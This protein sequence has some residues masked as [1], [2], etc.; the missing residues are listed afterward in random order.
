MVDDVSPP[1]APD[2]FFRADIRVGRVS[3]A[4][5]FPEARKPAFKL[6][7]DFGPLGYR[8]SSAQ[9]TK[10]YTPEQLVGRLV[11]AVVN[12]PAR[13]IAS[14]SSEVLILG[15]CPDSSDVVLL[16]PDFDVEPGTRIA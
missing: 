6:T 9:L 16:S 14:F 5:P 11:I 2:D 13:R 4:E 12:F 15:A 1:I 10:R 7:V 3:R 8:T